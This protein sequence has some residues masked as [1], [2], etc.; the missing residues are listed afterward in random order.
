MIRVYPSRHPINLY[1]E[2][3]VPIETHVNYCTISIAEWLR[4]TVKGFDLDR[5]HHPISIDVNGVT[6]E[7]KDWD[8]H[9][10]DAAQDIRVYPV[11]KGIEAATLAW[12]AIAVAAVA[13]VYSLS[14]MPDGMG[15]QEQGDQL[16]LGTAQANTVRLYEPIREVFGRDRIY[17][18]YIVQPVTRFVGPR[19][20]RTYMF[21]SVGIGPMALPG[22]D[23]KVGQTPFA[24]FGS[25]ISYTVYPPGADVSGDSRS[26]NWY[27]A[28]EVGSSKSATAGLDLDSPVDITAS[29]ADGLA[30]SDN[31]ITLVGNNASVYSGWT[32]GTIIN[33]ITPNNY[34]VGMSG[35]YSTI[36]GP[37]DDLEPFVG[38][39]VSLDTPTEDVDLVITSYSPYVAPVPG[40]GGSASYVLASAAPTTY[41]FE[42]VPV[43]WSLTYQGV[44]RSLSL[45]DDY[46]NM[47]GLVSE[48]TAQLSGM[49]LVAQD[50]SG[51]VRIIE[52]SS[53][54]Q[55]GAIAQS[56]APAAVF[57]SS[58][59]YS[60][61][62]PSSGGTAEQLAFI[63]LEYEGG[64]PFSGLPL[65]QQRLALG[66]RGNN[67]AITDIDDLTISL[68]RL[69][70]AGLVDSGWSGFVDRTLLDFTLNATAS[71]SDNWIGP[72][73]VCPEGEVIDRMEW[74]VFFP[75]GLIHV[76]KKGRDH[77]YKSIVIVEWADVDTGIWNTIVKTYA[78]ITRDGFGVT[79]YEDFE[80]PIR[81][82]I[83]MRRQ[84]YNDWSNSQDKTQWFAL[85]GRLL[86][87]PSS[88][89]DET[90]IALTIRTGERLSAMS[91]RKVSVVATKLY[92]NGDNQSVYGATR[93][94][95][96]SAGMQLSEID[97]EQLEQLEEDYWTPRG[98]KF[99]FSFSKQV[100]V[101]EALQMALGAGM[102]L[103]VLES[104]MLSAVREGNQT[105]KG[106]ITPHDQASELKVSFT[107]AGPDDYSGVDVKYI[108]PV[109][110]T[111]EIV[112]C[113]LPGLTA[114]KTET[115]ELAGVHDRTRA[116]R[117]GMRR[118]M[119]YR[120]QRLKV[121]TSTEM[122]ALAYQFMDLII[123]ANDIPGDQNISC[124]IENI[125]IGG[126]TATLLVS[127]PLDWT[128]SNTRCVIRRQDGTVTN[129]LTPTEV[130]FWPEY[131]GRALTLPA[132]AIDF[133][134][135][136]KIE[137]PRLL[138]CSS[139]KVGYPM[140]IE[141]IDPDEE[142][143]CSVRGVNYSADLY[144]YD[145]SSPT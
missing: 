112:E 114:L 27:I 96:E 92:E 19:D 48:L 7:P 55:G 64:T 79:E 90:T 124:L 76:D 84:E 89:P 41:D 119:K 123:F 73:M 136:W 1:P 130:D 122:D 110:F 106:L 49:G 45:I 144:Q 103:P 39:A 101:K 5:D 37:L 57:G 111:E 128:F 16:K 88:Y 66:Y 12:I 77:E 116:W 109:T 133:E 97:I 93:Y 54:F 145:D 140:I 118:L 125:I 6:I 29:N 18:D 72:F 38:M 40:A 3:G 46:I 102:S 43:T 51:Q 143:R 78:G 121:D 15:G 142:G 33:L 69:T 129:L 36:A 14:M 61:G 67:Y 80:T 21:L 34:L 9:I 20:V 82:M 22:G 138:F 95:C 11:P 68:N 62:S 50:H 74:D 75:A 71:I 120:L 85:R 60:T 98:E 137:P 30:L 107:S 59:T 52:P 53:P 132:S 87:R 131:R 134:P 31:T 63:T 35:A 25:D 2:N 47:S 94:I 135:N 83:R 127:E 13:I 113:R 100:T 86:S 70:D 104:G 117:I 108:N 105:P 42:T 28:P 139:D 10:I 32:V 17:P 44:T 23:M 141:S 91:D 24:A 8:K 99:D 56:G 26:E 81:P 58:P 4:R 115:F 65:G 126:G